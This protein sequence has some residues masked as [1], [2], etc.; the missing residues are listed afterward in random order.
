MT[1][2]NT[3]GRGKGLNTGEFSA[4]LRYTYNISSKMEYKSGY[5]VCYFVGFVWNCVWYPVAWI[6]LK[7]F[8]IG[9]AAN[10]CS[11]LVAALASVCYRKVCWVRRRSRL[12]CLSAV[13]LYFNYQP[14][15]FIIVIRRHYSNTDITIHRELSSCQLCRHWCHKR[16]TSNLASW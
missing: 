8:L 7:V 13:A 9:M 5:F 11:N 1:T 3:E 15:Q 6:I 10:G 2:D 4:Q 12:T 14:Y 16:V